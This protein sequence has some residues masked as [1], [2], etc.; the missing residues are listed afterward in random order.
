MRRSPV[1]AA[2][3]ALFLFVSAPFAGQPAREN[4]FRFSILGDRTGGAMPGV[5]EQVWRELDGLKPDF[6]INVG[7]TIEGGS[8]AAAP[9]EWSALRAIWDRYSYPRFFTPGNHDVWSAASR[10]LYEEQTGHPLSYSFDFESAHF[11]VLDNSGGP[12]LSAGQ[13]SFLE[14][15]LRHNRGRAPKFVFFHEPFWI[16]WLKLGSGEFPLHQIAREYGVSYVVSG[17]GHQL[18]HVERDGIHYVEAGSSGASISRGASRGQGYDQGW[19]P[20]H[21]FVT[22]NGRMVAVS[23]REIGRP[24]GKGRVTRLEDWDGNRLKQMPPAR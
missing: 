10:R 19:F 2:L 24:F 12:M 22:V 13:M 14:D 8:D 1:R 17:H 16:V 5:Y 23:V 3:F 7:D 9:R 20:Q 4:V 11:T 21:L 18:V 15:D 6:V